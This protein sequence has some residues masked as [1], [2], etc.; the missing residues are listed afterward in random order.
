MWIQD[1]G[2]TGKCNPYAKT[3]A[4]IFTPDQ[5]EATV[6]SMTTPSGPKPG[7]TFKEEVQA[8]LE[9]WEKD[10]LLKQRDRQKEGLLP[11][12]LE[13]KFRATAGEGQNWQ[14]FDIGF[15][16]S[17]IAGKEAEVLDVVKDWARECH[18]GGLMG[19]RTA[20]VYDFHD[21]G[22]KPHVRV[23]LGGYSWDE[24]SPPTQGIDRQQGRPE[25]REVGNVTCVAGATHSRGWLAKGSHLNEEFNDLAEKMSHL[26][27]GVFANGRNYSETLGLDAQPGASSTVQPVQTQ[28]PTTPSNKV[29]AVPRAG[30]APTQTG[31]DA[32]ETDQLRAIQEM[33]RELNRQRAALEQTQMAKTALLEKQAAE[34]TLALVQG[35]LT[36]EREAHAATTTALTTATEA[37]ALT[38]GE[39]SQAQTA[40]ETFQ[41]ELAEERAAREAL[42]IQA[43][44]QSV[45]I[46]DQ[47]STIAGLN[48]DLN[49]ETEA[50]ALTKG[51][52]DT[53]RQA[54]SDW[55]ERAVKAEREAQAAQALADGQKQII[56]DQRTSITDLRTD[57][58]SEKSGRA[59]VEQ[60]LATEQ[61]ARSAAEQTVKDLT[62][63]VEEN[64]GLKERLA[65]VEQENRDLEAK[66]ATAQQQ[67]EA[68]KKGLASEHEALTKGRAEM[69]VMAGLLNAASSEVTGKGAM[70]MHKSIIYAQVQNLQKHQAEHGALPE[71]TVG[72]LDKLLTVA[73]TYDKRGVL[74]DIEQQQ[75]EDAVE[76]GTVLIRHRDIMTPREEI[77][78]AEAA[79]RVAS[80]QLAQEH[81]VINGATE[82]ARRLEEARQAQQTGQRPEGQH[83]GRRVGPGGTGRGQGGGGI[84][85]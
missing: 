33:E 45:T 40:I 77:S 60:A 55:K 24:V 81:I 28:V 3:P 66:L 38:Q 78:V 5:D 1:Q 20:I 34:E 8:V 19:H 37:H 49:T 74:T 44:A 69:G 67:N 59:K 7:H 23:S 2:I 41:R 30:V 56:E 52:L 22:G 25:L 11:P 79:Q 82:K 62:P 54:A 26:G 16:P 39:L 71:P 64:K 21:D 18:A 75:R 13:T 57:L 63:L 46:A 80:G 84:A 70:E 51:E 27:I 12:L 32:L 31:L 15:E 68:L 36:V 42:A 43:Q 6:V 4:F 61:A 17:E 85:D 65:A 14:H 83:G 35:E 76:R 48:K 50:H 47:A 73:E 72:F 9:P 10:N 58:A 29:G 53:M